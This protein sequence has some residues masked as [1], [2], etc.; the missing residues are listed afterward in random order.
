M[1]P[2]RDLFSGVSWIIVEF[3]FTA[4]DILSMRK[5]ARFAVQKVAYLLH[6]LGVK[7]F[8]TLEFNLY[9]N[10]PYS[11][12][13]ADTYYAL[14]RD[15]PDKIYAFAREFHLE[16]GIRRI[17]EWFMK[18]RY[19]WM[20]IATTML[21]IYSRHPGLSF[22]NLYRLVKSAK[23]WIDRE[24]AYRVYRDLKRIKLIK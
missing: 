17:V 22:E 23:P 3:G 9:I 24:T 21:M 4:D 15:Y 16:P 7:G 13:L 2:R 20:E 14:A 11:P 5:Y 10:G 18:K 6:Y 8:S 12:E 19:W 1:A